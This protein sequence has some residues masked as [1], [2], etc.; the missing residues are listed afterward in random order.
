MGIL[1]DP[2]REF[3]SIQIFYIEDKKPNGNST[4]SFIKSAKDLATWKNKGYTEET[5]VKRLREEAQQAQKNA[6]EGTNVTKGYDPSKIIQLLETHWR[7]IT[8][9]DQN[10]INTRCMTTTPAADGKMTIT[11]DWIKYR[12]QKLKMCLKRWDL[13]G[14]QNEEIPV[15]D[16]N[17]DML[18][19]DVAQ[20]LIDNFERVTEP[21]GDDLGN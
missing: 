18:H 19:P 10:S 9:K 2:N 7:Q 8:W 6:G 21:S 12:D 4:F 5:E 1:L 11:L 13:K 3:V 15:N 14:P 16:T 20:A 17:I